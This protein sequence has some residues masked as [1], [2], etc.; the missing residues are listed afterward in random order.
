MTAT[1][2]LAIVEDANGVNIDDRTYDTLVT[3][4]LSV[5]LAAEDC[6]ATL[7]RVATDVLSDAYPH[8]TRVLYGPSNYAVAII[9][10]SVS[11]PPVCADLSAN[12][13]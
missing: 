13:R 7:Y 8:C 4:L 2:Q 10:P 11:P 9:H 12:L 1:L 5:D 3:A 6:A